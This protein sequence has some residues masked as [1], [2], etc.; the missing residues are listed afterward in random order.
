MSLIGQV[1][2]AVQASNGV[3]NLMELSRQLNIQPTALRDILDFCAQKG[4]L[5]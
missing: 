5:M 4:V 2:E 3:V 1:L